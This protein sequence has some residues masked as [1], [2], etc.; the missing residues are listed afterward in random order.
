V[1][2]WAREDEGPDKGKGEESVSQKKKTKEKNIEVHW[3]KHR[4]DAI[5]E[6]LQVFSSM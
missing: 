1:D 2:L 4:N 3:R 6:F 5:P